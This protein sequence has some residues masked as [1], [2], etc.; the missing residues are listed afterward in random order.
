M[1]SERNNMPAKNR[2]TYDILGKDVV[3]HPKIGDRILWVDD[4]PNSRINSSL[5]RKLQVSGYTV[6]TAKSTKEGLQRFKPNIYSAV[7]SDMGRIESGT[8]VKDAGLNLCEEIRKMD[9]VVNIIIFT[10]QANVNIYKT[11]AKKV[12]AKIVNGRTNLLNAL[13]EISTS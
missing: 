7:I 8:Y 1:S 13:K 12:N 4:N 3:G 6:I 2:G 11:K 5:R 10:T 9:T